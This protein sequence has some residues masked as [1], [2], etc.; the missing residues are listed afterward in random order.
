MKMVVYCPQRRGTLCQQPPNSFMWCQSCLNVVLTLSQHCLKETKLAKSCL[1]VVQKSQCGP[2]VV[3]KL[4]QYFPN[5]A[6]LK[7]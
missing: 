7:M 2:K 3:P 6:A 4:S 1:S 5:V